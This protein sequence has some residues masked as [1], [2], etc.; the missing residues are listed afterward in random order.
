MPADNGKR[1]KNR[2]FCHFRVLSPT[3]LQG[4]RTIL[5]RLTSVWQVASPPAQ[6]LQLAKFVPKIKPESTDE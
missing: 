3:F 4:C 5:G 6:A 2:R 1:Q